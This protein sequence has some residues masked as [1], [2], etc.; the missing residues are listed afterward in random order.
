MSGSAV[1][2]AFEKQIVCAAHRHHRATEGNH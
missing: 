2:A 1:K